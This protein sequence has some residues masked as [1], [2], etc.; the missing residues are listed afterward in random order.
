MHKVLIVDDEENIVNMLRYA[1]Q[2]E[3]Y[4]VDTA[5]DGYEA[6]E[7]INTFKPDVIL[8]DIMMPNK[9][10]YQICKEFSNRHNII[11]LTAKSDITD[12]IAGIELGA[13][14]YITKP[15]D[16]REVIIRIKALL[17]RKAK[18][19]HETITLN[20]LTMMTEH[21]RAF[22]DGKELELT[23]IE[24]NLLY[25]MLSNVNKVY[26]REEL[27]DKVWGY[28]YAG[29]TRS[30]DIHIQRL[31][32]KLGDFSKCIKSIYGVGYRINGDSCYED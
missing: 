16:I 11:L 6:T 18:E 14:D 24:Y 1:V 28:E 31:R 13:D 26:T 30:V 32:R 15:F 12:K 21:R 29:E 3:G 2:K 5:G 4:A 17:R 19:V 9:D 25:L 10:G 22:L 7:K 20:Q 27:L 8:L 23:P